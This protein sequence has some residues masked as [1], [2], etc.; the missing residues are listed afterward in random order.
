MLRQKEP[1]THLEEAALL[2]AAEKMGEYQDGEQ[3]IRVNVSR[4]VLVFL[5][6]GMPPSVLAQER[7]RL[8]SERDAEGR[9]LIVW[10]RPKKGGRAAYTRVPASKRLSPWIEEFLLTPRPRW[11]DYWRQMLHALART[12]G[13]ASGG[14]T[15]TNLCPLAL[16][17]TFGVRMLER[18]GN[19]EIVRQ[20]MNCSRETLD[21]YLRLLGEMVDE[22]LAKA[23]W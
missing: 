13:A 23:G 22:A 21:Y 9:V 6:T 5:D 15:E 3:G 18:T 12:I 10:D 1:L 7:I 17:H 8:R 19:P 4:A 2:L 20:L 14:L 11:G 16:R